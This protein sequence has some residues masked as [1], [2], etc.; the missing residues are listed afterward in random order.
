MAA[1]Y[2]TD[3]TRIPAVMLRYEFFIPVL[4]ISPKREFDGT[5]KCRTG[6]VDVDVIHLCCSSYKIGYAVS[7]KL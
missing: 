5:S 7:N 2:R 4:K 3:I 6:W 1:L